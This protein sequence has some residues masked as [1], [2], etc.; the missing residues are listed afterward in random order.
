MANNGGHAE[1]RAAAPLVL[2]NQC[3]ALRAVTF[4]ARVLRISNKSMYFEKG[5]QTKGA[6][7]TGVTRRCERVQIQTAISKFKF[8]HSNV[9]PG[10][11]TAI[12]TSCL[13]VYKYEDPLS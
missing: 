3:A 4:D 7:K 5:K 12:T 13:V 9:T 2:N 6:C 8:K 10:A 1:L 11:V